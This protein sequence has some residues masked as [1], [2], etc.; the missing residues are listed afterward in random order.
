MRRRLVLMCCAFLFAT[1]LTSSSAFC[2]TLFKLSDLTDDHRAYLFDQIDRFGLLTAM[3]NFCQ[4][5]PHMIEKLSP[6]LDGCVD[7]ASIAVVKD[8]FNQAVVNNSGA[9]N[10]GAPGIAT[11]VARFEA[12]IVNVV[13]QVRTGC[14][15]RTLYSISIPRL[16]FP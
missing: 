6:I 3:L 16:N 15:L 9:Y 13:S 12:L 7:E 8:R 5:P 11:A 2:Q 10:C 4:R 14:R 1:L